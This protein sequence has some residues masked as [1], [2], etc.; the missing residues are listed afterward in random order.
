MARENLDWDWNRAIH[1]NRE[2]TDEFV[3]TLIPEV[4]KLKQSGATPITVGIDSGGGSLLA[5]EQLLKVLKTPDQEGR[6]C[7][8]ITIAVNKAYSAAASLLAMGD[9]A[10]AM[11]SAQILYH[12]VR[13]GEVYDVTPA[14][15]TQAARHL[16]RE[17]DRIALLIAKSVAKRLAWN[18]IDLKKGFGETKKKFPD[19]ATIV[20]ELGARDDLQN[21]IPRFDLAGLICSIFAQTSEVGDRLLRKSLEHLTV[22]RKLE[23][24][25]VTFTE[26]NKPDTDKQ[27]LFRD[28]NPLAT[29]ISQIF[30]DKPPF[31]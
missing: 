29:I 11:P 26:H 17:N 2:I 10:I 7:T 18:S 4:L 16:N 25:F 28:D 6:V 20:N 15:A 27:A 12:D 13:L 21:D 22:W 5:T 30:K 8:I 9:Y 14:K 3:A 31:T 19:L 1:V 24:A 23:M